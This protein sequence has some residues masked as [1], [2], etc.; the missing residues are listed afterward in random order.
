MSEK[1]LLH[2]NLGSIEEITFLIQNVLSSD[3]PKK[4]DDIRKYCISHSITFAYSLS[5]T[6]QLLNDMSIINLAD[7]NSVILTNPG[8]ELKKLT[9]FTSMFASSFIEHLFQIIKNADLLSS[10]FPLDCIKY[11]ISIDAIVIRNSGIPLK[12][13][14]LKNLLFS[15]NFFLP[16]AMSPNLIIVNPSYQEFFNSCVISWLKSNALQKISYT[17]FTIDQLKELNKSKELCGYEAE[18]YVEKYEKQRLSNHP[19]VNKIKIIS[20]IDVTAGYDIVSFNSHT[21]DIIDRFIEVKSFVHSLSFYWSRNELETARL[22]AENYFLYLVDRMKMKEQSYKPLIIE[23]PFTNIFLSE[24]WLKQENS[25][26]VTNKMPL[27]SSLQ[28][29]IVLDY[30]D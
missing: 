17:T 6:L 19:L 23:N 28:Q 30:D 15:L 11:D 27:E 7:D 26:Y 24:K 25:W 4:I 14:G 9:S 10:F 18:L 13:A 5:G 8:I 3:E 21:S 1:L 22:K 20:N 2:D 16:H 29:K 12:Y